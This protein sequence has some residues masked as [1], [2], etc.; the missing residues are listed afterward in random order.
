MVALEMELDKKDTGLQGSVPPS[1]PVT[2]GAS[3]QPF[4]A[5]VHASAPFNTCDHEVQDSDY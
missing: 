2:T 1:A 4:A 5:A 3:S